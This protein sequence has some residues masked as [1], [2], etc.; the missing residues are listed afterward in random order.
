[1]LIN[2]QPNI[3][4]VVE[5]LKVKYLML[6]KDILEESHKQ[7]LCSLPVSVPAAEGHGAVGPNDYGIN[8]YN[9]PKNNRHYSCQS[10]NN[11]AVGAINSTFKAMMAPIVDAASP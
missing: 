4:V 2:V 7:Q 1:M 11:G 10:Q 5:Q 9:I 3:M 8:G 6:I